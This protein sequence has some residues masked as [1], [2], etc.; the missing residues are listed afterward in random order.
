MALLSTGLA[1]RLLGNES[2][3][4]LMRHGVIELRD[5]AIPASPDLAA[6]GN[7]IARITNAGASWA[8]GASAGGLEWQRVG[9]FAV[10]APGQSWQL[11]GVVTG[12][13]TWFRVRAN[14][15]ETGVGASDVLRIDGV[16]AA[17]DGSPTTG[18]DLFLPTAQVAA[19]SVRRI[20]NF[21]FSL[22]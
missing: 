10:P 8:P 12:T 17:L 5:G 15:P 14:A 13:P 1:G 2:F 6:T 9:R 20:D 21:T 18:A 11:T 3:E 4:Q 16:V 22:T 19:G 7:L